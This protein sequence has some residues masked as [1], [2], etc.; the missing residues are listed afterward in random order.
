MCWRSSLRQVFPPDI[1]QISQEA[2]QDSRKIRRQ[3]GVSRRAAEETGSR[4]GKAR[5]RHVSQVREGFR[6]S[7]SGLLQAPLRGR[8]SKLHALKLIPNPRALNYCTDKLPEQTYNTSYLRSR[9][10]PDVPRTSS[11][12]RGEEAQSAPRVGRLQ[13]TLDKSQTVQPLVL[14][15][16]W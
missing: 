12:G 4:G 9:R 16:S 13:C 15:N 6:A 2:C 1:A 14:L 5:P 7:W 8:F 3:G 11:D 10:L